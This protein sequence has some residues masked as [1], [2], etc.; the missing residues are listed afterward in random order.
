M[1]ALTSTRPMVILMVGVGPGVA[2]GSVA[3]DAGGSRCSVT[4]GCTTVIVGAKNRLA[5]RE[6]DSGCS[7]FWDC[8]ATGKAIRSSTPWRV[9]C[10]SAD[11]FACPPVFLDGSA[12]F[13]YPAASGTGTGVSRWDRCV[14][15]VSDAPTA[16]G[17]KIGAGVRVTIIGA[18]FDPGCA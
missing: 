2:I 17:W 12:S 14:G 18:G 7:T 11:W 10:S 9:V 15:F 6:T 5:W 3:A 4:C 16:P 1:M 13:A 8:G